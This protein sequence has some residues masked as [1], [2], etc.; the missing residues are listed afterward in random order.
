[1]KNKFMVTYITLQINLLCSQDLV[2]T[3][4]MEVDFNSDIDLRDGVLA[5]GSA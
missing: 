1:M 4:M 5:N 2:D 3:A